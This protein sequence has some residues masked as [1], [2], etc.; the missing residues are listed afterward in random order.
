M[1]VGLWFD[2]SQNYKKLL[3]DKTKFKNNPRPEHSAKVLG[4]RVCYEKKKEERKKERKKER[5]FV[6]GQCLH[7]INP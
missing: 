2:S 5:K 4:T 7:S 6:R 1:I 3:S